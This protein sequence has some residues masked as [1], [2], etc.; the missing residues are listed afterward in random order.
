LELLTA[1]LQPEDS[2]AV[3]TY[4]Q[5][6]NTVR[7]FGAAGIHHNIEQLFTHQGYS[8]ATSFEQGMLIDQLY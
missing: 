2:F 4:A 6:A 3:V 7:P 5:S 8:G 1:K